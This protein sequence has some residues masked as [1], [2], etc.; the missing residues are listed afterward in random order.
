[1]NKKK[2]FK[3]LII[4]SI[5]CLLTIVTNAHVTFAEDGEEVGYD[6]QA[7]LPENQVDKTHTYFDLRM[8]PNQKQTVEMAINN[9]SNQEATYEISIN[10]AYTNKQ[11]FIDY[12]D[13][14]VNLDKSLK[15]SIQDI[16]TYE[17]EVTVKA[18]ESVQYPITI[19]MPADSFDGQIMAG[20]QVMKKEKTDD[21]N[22]I[23]NKVGYILGL[24]LTETDNEVKRKIELID[25]KPEV[26][27]GKTSVV[28]TLRNP[29]MDAIGKLKYVVNITDNAG[30]NVRSITYDSDMQIAPNSTYGLAIDWENKSLVAGDYKMNLLVTD[31]KNN[32]WEFDEEFTITAK[33]AKDIN[34]VTV[35]VG[36]VNTPP[37]WLIILIGIV[38]VLIV[39]IVV[40]V[41]K[42]QKNNKSN[43]KKKVH[44]KK[45]KKSRKI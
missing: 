28:A 23:K 7:I 5:M 21:S 30:E 35:D 17:K 8:K 11:G 41:I 26:S 6:I 37:I 32:K 33:E 22:S 18:N 43:S 38:L 25:V 20:I 27:F 13:S 12:A 10:Q 2:F 42:K 36:K 34:K 39:I 45:S 29:T 19:A 24:N 14:N 40:L 1:M 3:R 4:S 16:V 31:A 44:T 9:T 15:Y